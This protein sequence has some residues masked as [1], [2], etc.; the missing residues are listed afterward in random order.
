[1]RFFRLWIPTCNVR[2][3]KSP[4]GALEWDRDGDSSH[5]LFR[6]LVKFLGT[7]SSARTALYSQRTR[8]VNTSTLWD[9]HWCGMGD[10]RLGTTPQFSN[11][12]ALPLPY[13]CDWM[14]HGGS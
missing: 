5:T 12:I 9:F 11:T 14:E 3:W 8:S 7:S 2:H 10:G 6:P 1:M 4:T 13:E